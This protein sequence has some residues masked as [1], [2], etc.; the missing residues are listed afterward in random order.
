VASYIGI[1]LILLGPT[2]AYWA[3]ILFYEVLF[4]ASILWI[5]HRFGSMRGL[6]IAAAMYLFFTPWYPEIYMGQ[7]SFLQSVFILGLLL[8]AG[9]NN[10]RAGG[11]W[12]ASVLWKLNTGICL[13]AII[14]WR[15]WRPIIWLIVL[16][17]VTCGPYFAVHPVDGLKF[18][19]INFRPP[20]PASPGNFG[21]LGVI[22]KLFYC[23]ADGGDTPARP[24]AQYIAM[25]FFV[26]IGI[27]ATV[28]AP[29]SRFAECICLWLTTYFLVY[30]DVWEHQYVMLLPAVVF[31]YLRRRGIIPWLI[32]LIFACPTTYK[33][34]Y[35]VLHASVV[36]GLPVDLMKDTSFFN[37]WHFSLIK[38]LGLLAM[39]IYCVWL[40]AGGGKD[41]GGQE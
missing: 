35:D 15:L 30:I 29:K 28:R 3:W 11:W 18:I 12:A 4:F 23:H 40:T 9:G 5:G 1:P 16:I 13:P 20:G 34:F 22:S 21:F 25:A 26:I 7:Y 8:G 36:A 24:V 33:Y 37:D 6:H 2:A 17:I 10:L 14:R 41:S 32:W 38:P 19:L 31:L 27:A 39:Y